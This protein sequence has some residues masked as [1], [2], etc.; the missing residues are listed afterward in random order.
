[1]FGLSRSSGG[2]TSIV[3]VGHSFFVLPRIRDIEE[4]PIIGWDGIS[5]HHD[6]SVLSFFLNSERVGG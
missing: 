4:E 6:N 2:F 1:M 3:D 5:V